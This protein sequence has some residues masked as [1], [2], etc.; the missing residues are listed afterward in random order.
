MTTRR[1]DNLAAALRLALHENLKKINTVMPGVIV[2][3]DDTTRRATVR[4]ALRNLLHDG[5]QVQRPL[6]RNA[7]VWFP[8]AGGYSIRYQLS[9]GDNVLLLFSQ[10]GL[11]EWRSSHTESAP[12]VGPILSENDAIVLPGLGRQPQ[13]A[14]AVDDALVLNGPGGYLALKDDVVETNMPVSIKADSEVSTLPTAGEDYEGRLVHLRTAS[15]TELWFCRSN[16]ADGRGRPNSWEWVELT[17]G[18]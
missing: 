18:P 8:E 16:G 2:E 1:N 4:S 3:Y 5:Q 12:G 11:D 17:G 13:S 6:I 7:P 10:R 9:A 14:A 15:G